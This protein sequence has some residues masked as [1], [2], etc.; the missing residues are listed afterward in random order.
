MFKKCLSIFAHA[1]AKMASGTR[2]NKEN[3]C[4]KTLN[5]FL[6][7]SRNLIKMVPFIKSFLGKLKVGQPTPNVKSAI[8]KGRNSNNMPSNMFNNNEH[9]DPSYI[10]IKHPSHKPKQ[11]TKANLHNFLHELVVKIN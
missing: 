8:I 9:N 3:Q 11:L 6:R 1:F 4:K 5:T 7:K 2:K 10:T